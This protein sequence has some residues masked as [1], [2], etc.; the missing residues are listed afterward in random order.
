M[1]DLAASRIWSGFGSMGSAS[2]TFPQIAV[3]PAERNRESEPAGSRN[4]VAYGK[5]VFPKESGPVR[6]VFTVRFDETQLQPPSGGV[7]GR[8]SG[9]KSGAT[10]YREGIFGDGFRG[11]PPPEVVAKLSKLSD[12]QIDRLIKQIGEIR[13]KNP[14]ISSEDRRTL[15]V[16]MLDRALQ[17]RR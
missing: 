7:G 11:P 1:S 15:F 4:T 5:F 2:G 13:D 17:E 9:S 14:Q 10:N 6:R 8:S 12:S 3:R 16:K